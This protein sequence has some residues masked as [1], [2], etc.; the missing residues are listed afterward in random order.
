MK[1]FLSA[2]TCSI[3]W[4][5]GVLQIFILHNAIDFVNIRKFEFSIMY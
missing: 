4:L 3:D 5:F 2:N 1:Y